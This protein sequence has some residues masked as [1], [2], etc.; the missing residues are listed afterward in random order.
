MSEPLRI[1]L[2]PSTCWGSNLRSVF[3]PSQWE[4]C[5]GYARTHSAHPGACTVCGGRGARWPVECHEAWEYRLGA[6]V[7]TQ[8]LVGLDALCPDCHHC[9]HLGHLI[10][11][12]SEEMFHRAL[13]H[14]MKVNNWDVWQTEEYVQRAFEMHKVRSQFEWDLDLRWLLGAGFP[15]A[16]NARLYVPARQRAVWAGNTPM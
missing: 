8:V 12:Q 4:W 5:K 11:T 14:L 3:S 16:E 10:V 2:V 6:R 13:V 9:K 7:P 1:E 15:A